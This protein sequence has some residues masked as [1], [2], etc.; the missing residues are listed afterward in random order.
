M[1]EYPNGTLCAIFGA[2]G[3]S[4]IITATLQNALHILDANMSVRDALASPR[5]HDQ[6]IPNQALFEETYDNTT[7]AFMRERGHNT[8][9]TS[10]AGSSAQAIKIVNGRFEAGGEP[11]QKN[12]AGLTI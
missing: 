3:G 2:S 7:V 9:W 4:K 5:L 1:V 12:S 8:T 10:S 6:L 11:R